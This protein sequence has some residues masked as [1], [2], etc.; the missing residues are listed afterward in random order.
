[1]GSAHAARRAAAAGAIA[2]VATA[3]ITFSNA[4]IV[5]VI[6]ATSPPSTTTC[7]RKKGRSGWAWCPSSYRSRMPLR[8]RRARCRLT[9]L[10]DVSVPFIGAA[11][12]LADW[13][14]TPS[15][16]DSS[17]EGQGSLCATVHSPLR[18]LRKGGGCPASRRRGMGRWACSPVESADSARSPHARRDALQQ[19]IRTS[20]YGA[21]KLHTTARVTKCCNPITR[22]TASAANEASSI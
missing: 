15:R 17:L 1:V 14:E 21:L 18:L 16:S 19:S 8:V 9:C 2:S 10:S 22:R 7:T 12:A 20:G 3:A 11:S 4:S 6:H 13:Q 5:A